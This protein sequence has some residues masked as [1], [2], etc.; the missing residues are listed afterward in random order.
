LRDNKTKRYFQNIAEDFDDIYDNRGTFLNRF[1]NKVFRKGMYERATLAVKECGNVEG[2]S[3]LDIGCGSGR[4]ALVLAAKGADVLGIDYSLN[5]VGLADGYLKS[6]GGNMNAKFVCCDFMAD[7]RSDKLF[8]IT[9]ALG[10]LDYITSPMPFLKK[11]RELTKEQMIVSYPARFTLQMPIRKV[12]L[13]TRRCP[14]HFYTTRQLTRMYE[15]MA[16]RELKIMT[17]PTGARMPTDYLVKA[18][19]K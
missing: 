15:P 17:M 10:V 7:F 5:M 14:V 8:D 6:Q 1:I 13:W 3:I 9:L 2:K 19:I 4:I 12:W 11:M 16:I 18:V